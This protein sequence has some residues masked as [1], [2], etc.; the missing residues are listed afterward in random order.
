M[1]EGLS[2]NFKKKHRHNQSHQH[3]LCLRIDLRF[4]LTS[5]VPL[6]ILVMHLLQKQKKNWRGMVKRLINVTI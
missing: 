4:G 2:I 1:W 5:K 6:D 3:Y